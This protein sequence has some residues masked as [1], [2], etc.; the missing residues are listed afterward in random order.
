MITVCNVTAIEPE[1]NVQF[2][3]GSAHR[4]QLVWLRSTEDDCGET[5]GVWT[6]PCK[7]FDDTIERVR[8]R[9]LAVGDA[10]RVSLRP[11]YRRATA[12][13]VE[14]VFNTLHVRL[15]DN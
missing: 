11:G 15:L 5:E 10:V 8:Q 13:G 1:R 3:D 4:V 12:N 2:R 6:T 7:I 9:G 14:D